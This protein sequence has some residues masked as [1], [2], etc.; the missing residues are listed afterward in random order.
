[1]LCMGDGS[2]IFGN[3]GR[4]T[5][6]KWFL[7]VTTHPVETQSYQYSTLICV[8]SNHGP[9][10]LHFSSLIAKWSRDKGRTD[11]NELEIEY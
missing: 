4:Y 5:R 2:I 10:L 1:M 6:R 9:N 8:V 11:K 3:Q 7:L